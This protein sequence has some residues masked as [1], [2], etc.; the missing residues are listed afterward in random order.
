VPLVCGAAVLATALLAVWLK[1][2]GPEAD[3]RIPPSGPS[4]VAARPGVA[5]NVEPPSIDTRPAE[6]VAV[7]PRRS[8]QSPPIEVPVQV[9][10]GAPLLV[11]TSIAIDPIVEES[12]TQI[13]PLRVAP[14]SIQ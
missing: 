6:T 14:L 13:E 1:P 3:P 9:T 5:V 8:A 10:D 12:V 2:G 7:R 4:D 11:V